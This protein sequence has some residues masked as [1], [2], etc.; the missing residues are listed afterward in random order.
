MNDKL[1]D[2][3]AQWRGDVEFGGKYANSKDELDAELER[4]REALAAQ[5]GEGGQDE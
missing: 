4:R 2:A 3:L 1:M 5:A